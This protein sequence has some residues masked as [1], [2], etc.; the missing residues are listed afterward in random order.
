[1]LYESSDC[2]YYSDCGFYYYLD[3]KESISNSYSFKTRYFL[4]R[5]CVNLYK[6]VKN[7]YKMEKEADE[8]L[9]VCADRLTDLLRCSDG[10]K[11]QY[12]QA[13]NML[14]GEKIDIKRLYKME[15]PLQQKIKYT[16][17]SL[18]GA[19]IHCRLHAMLHRKLC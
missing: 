16:T 9:L 2:V 8:M 5:N 6:K 18:F 19:T 4:Y 15:I 12:T 7:E 13:A 10:P 3:Q 17:L 1:M 14:R 11:E